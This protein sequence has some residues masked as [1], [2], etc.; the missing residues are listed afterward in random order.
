MTILSNL[1]GGGSPMPLEFTSEG[2]MTNPSQPCF[3]IKPTNDQEDMAV[4]SG[5]DLVFDNEVIDVGN[6][7]TSNAF[8]APVTGKYQL[9]VNLRLTDVDAES[10]YY[11]IT[12][13][14]SNRS[15]FYTFTPKYTSDLPYKTCTINVIADMDTNDT[16][17]VRFYQSTGTAQVN[18][19]KVSTFSGALIC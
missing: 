2:E 12:L 14:T 3:L 4:G 7:F 16:A 9:N 6:N 19:A 5:V 15:Y 10:G 17:C 18:V 1:F 8:T 13:L 11:A